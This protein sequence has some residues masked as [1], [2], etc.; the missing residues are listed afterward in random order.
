MQKGQTP[1]HITATQN[2]TEMAQLLIA[3]GAHVS[4]KDN[5]IKLLLIV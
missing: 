3:A 1:L 2:Y 4:L 5:A